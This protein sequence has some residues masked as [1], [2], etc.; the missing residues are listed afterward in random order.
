LS[1]VRTAHSWT[2]THVD[3]NLEEHVIVLLKTHEALAHRVLK[4]PAASSGESRRT[5][6][7]R[8]IAKCDEPAGLLVP[9]REAEA[10]HAL[11]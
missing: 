5:H 8:Q 11:A 1:F 9:Q 3:S 4:D 2:N 6:R 7:L 10:S